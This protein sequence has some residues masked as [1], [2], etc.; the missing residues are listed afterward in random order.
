MVAVLFGCH[1]FFKLFHCTQDASWAD[2]L[3]VPLWCC[4]HT[5][6]TAFACRALTSHGVQALVGTRSSQLLHI[7]LRLAAQPASGVSAGTQA[8]ALLSRHSLGTQLPTSITALPGGISSR[9]L[10][11]DSHTTLPQ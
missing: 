3:L 4:A 2:S 1:Q 11:M 7:E 8:D 9:K 6:P 5:L 10:P